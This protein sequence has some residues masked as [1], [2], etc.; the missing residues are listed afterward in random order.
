MKWPVQLCGS[1][2]RSPRGVVV[3]AVFA[4]ERAP[5]HMSLLWPHKHPNPSG[6]LEFPIC[7]YDWDS[8]T[9]GASSLPFVL[10]DSESKH[11]AFQSPASICTRSS[12]LLFGRKVTTKTKRSRLK[13]RLITYCLISI[14]LYSTYADIIMQILFPAWI[15]ALPATMKWFA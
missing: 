12:L 15:M 8:S 4:G 11:F 2:L 3:Y 1:G 5:C 7:F 14:L 13:E 10:Y 6:V 9:F